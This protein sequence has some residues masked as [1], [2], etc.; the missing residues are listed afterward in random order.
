MAFNN[1]STHKCIEDN[2]I[3][4]AYENFQHTTKRWENYWWE[5][6]VQIFNSCADFAKKFVIDFE[7]RIL[8]PIIEK[9]KIVKSRNATKGIPIIEK[10]DFSNC[11]G[12]Q[13]YLFKFFNESDEILWTKI[14]T[15]TRNYLERCKREIYD[16]NKAGH[17][18]AKVIIENV[19]NCG[20]TPAEGFES[21]LRADFIKAFPSTFRKNDRFFNIDI[22]V[23]T[24]NSICAK[25]AKA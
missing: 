10:G 2:D 7:K 9:I 5:C 11:H 24:F 21:Q 19:L 17:G 12:E 20:D 1:K 22:P 13:V 4:S 25:Y 3:L 14:G 6:V 15:T 16:Y 8:S 18:V 23:E